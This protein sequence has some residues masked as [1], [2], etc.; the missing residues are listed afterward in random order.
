MSKH[1][2]LEQITLIDKKN[3][4]EKKNSNKLNN[5]VITGIVAVSLFMTGCDNGEASATQPEITPPPTE[6][7]EMVNNTNSSE[8]EQAEVNPIIMKELGPKTEMNITT[9]FSNGET[10]DYSKAPVNLV[11]SYNFEYLTA[12]QQA[13]LKE[14]EAMELSEF[15]KLSNEEQSVFSSWV[16]KNNQPRFEKMLSAYGIDKQYSY[17][18]NKHS[19]IVENFEY[20]NIFLASLYIQDPES[21]TGSLKYDADTAYKLETIHQT[22][23]IDENVYSTTTRYDE[24]IDFFKDYIGLNISDFE[25]EILKT[26][27]M[28]IREPG[29]TYAG[30]IA[31]LKFI[32]SKSITFSKPDQQVIFQITP[33]TAIDGQKIELTQLGSINDMEHAAE[34]GN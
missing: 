8:A 19:E 14:Y 15:R 11:E 33:I 6:S 26:G 7:S 20:I 24:K 3:S 10:V 17:Y 4:K 25:T 22:P 30:I 18:V 2:N 32:G 5:A 16:L 9:E 27:N 28:E 13:K 29:H 1:D 34:F 23:S 21:K 31:N 12:E